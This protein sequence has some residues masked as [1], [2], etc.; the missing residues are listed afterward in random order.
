KKGPPMDTKKLEVLLKAIETGNLTAAGDEM[1]FTQSG[2]SHLIKSIENELGFQLLIRGKSGVRLTPDGEELLP[3]IRE[4]VNATE[5]LSQYS[6]NIRGM[7]SGRIR[8]GTYT[9]V[10]IFW[11]PRIIEQFSHDYPGIRIELAELDNEPLI[12]KQLSD[13]TIDIAFMSNPSG[14]NEWIPL[15]NDRIV[16]LLPKGHPLA[17][18]EV[19]TLSDMAN[20]PFIMPTAG[21]DSDIKRIMDSL[22]SGPRVVFSSMDFRAIVAMVQH[23]LGISVVPEMILTDINTNAVIKEFSPAR[24]RP[25]GIAVRSLANASLASRTFIKYAK[26]V[27]MGTPMEEYTIQRSSANEDPV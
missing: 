7:S 10:S 9:S 3:T 1:G 18:K 23:G 27:I 26:T 21:F 20:Q 22:D 2:V 8:I 12:E 15:A 14:L 11:M 6:S 16:A 5:R 19:L 13:G 24:Y 4:I 25:L 17:D